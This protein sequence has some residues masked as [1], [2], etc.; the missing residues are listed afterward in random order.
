LAAPENGP[1]T[2]MKLLYLAPEYLLM[3][4]LI[5]DKGSIN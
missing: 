3:D 5:A 4:G 2:F 1:E